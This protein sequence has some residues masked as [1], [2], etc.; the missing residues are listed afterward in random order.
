MNIPPI[1]LKAQYKLVRKQIRSSLDEILDNQQL[2]LG[3]YCAGIEEQ[4]S[5]YAGVPCA[6][7]CAN[8]TDALILALMAIDLKPGDEVITTPY[9]FFSTASSV[10]ILGGRPVFVDIDAKTMNIDP[11]RIERV[12]TPRTKAITVVHLFGK[13]CDMDAVKTIAEKHKLL[14]IEDCAQSLGSRRNGIMSGAFGDIAATS[15]YPTKNLG[16]IGEGGMVYTKRAE[17][18]EKVR[19]LRV[20][21]MGSQYF[22]EMIG[23]NSRLDEIKACALVAKFPHLETWNSKRKANARY[24][25]KHFKKL[26]IILPHVD[27]DASHIFHHYVIRTERRDE[28][29]AYLKQQGIM[30]G[31]YYPL[32]LHLQPCFNY[33]GYKEGDFPVSEHAA[34]TA[35]ALPIY[36]EL[37][38]AE[39]AY[40]VETVK[41]FF[42]GR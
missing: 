30:T 25:T 9:T 29:Q 26:P 33:L 18:G 38:V 28:L 6:V 32:P 34:K 35:L 4:V 41:A 10:A 39:R 15:F 14:I 16:G 17:L 20:H 2:I 13:V 22:H 40:V 11:E 19:K 31:V 42:D 8:G 21:G 12:I 27:D 36:P 5:R 23:L 24:Y 1:N 37:K 3:K 7:S